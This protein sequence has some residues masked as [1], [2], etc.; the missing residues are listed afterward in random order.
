MT[1][2]WEIRRR[3]DCCTATGRPFE[4]NEIFYTLLFREKEGFR[5]EDLGEDAWRALPPEP[6]PFSFWR[7]KF[8]PPPP[9]PPEPLPKEDAEGLLRRLIAAND[10]AT[11]NARYILALMLERKRLLRPVESN[12][13]HLLVYEHAKSGESFVL[14]NPRLSLSQIPEVQREVSTLLGEAAPA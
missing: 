3:S 13:D 9:P 4:E 12:D 14:P 5:R 7:S 1:Q 6:R 10:P 11:V 8:E 2:D